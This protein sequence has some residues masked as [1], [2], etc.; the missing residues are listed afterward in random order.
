MPYDYASDK[1]GNIT[2]TKYEKTWGRMEVYLQGD[3][4]RQFL[5][6][7]ELIDEKISDVKKNYDAG[8]NLIAEYFVDS[9][10]K[11]FR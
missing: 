11:M 7:I 1:I 8:Q 10:T 2:L 6:E 4:A 9:F 3:D 5:A